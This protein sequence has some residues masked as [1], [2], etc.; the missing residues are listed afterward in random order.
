MRL[1]TFG[2]LALIDPD[3]TRRAATLRKPLTILAVAAASAPD[4]V[5][6][7]EL[8]LLL[9]PDSPPDR[10]R[11]ALSQALYALRQAIGFAPLVGSA[12]LQ[13]DS[14][15]VSDLAA[16]REA[17]AQRDVDRARELSTGRF[18]AGVR[19]AGSP[20]FD[21]WTDRLQRSID[22][23][24]SVLMLATARDA[25]MRRQRDAVSR[26]Q[27]AA[28]RLLL[29]PLVVREAAEA[30]QRAGNRAAGLQLLQRHVE[31]LSKELGVDADAETRLLMRGLRDTDAPIGELEPPSR[32]A[33]P[34]PPLSISDAV[35]SAPPVG[36]A[37]TSSGVPSRRRWAW[38]A[39]M[40]AVLLL[41]LWV[42]NAREQPPP[43]FGERGATRL[44]V[45]PFRYE[46][47]T[48]LRYLGAG[49]AE[50]IAARLAPLP[51][52]TLYPPSL[53]ANSDST[54][55]MIV[56]T[57]LAAQFL[58]EGTVQTDRARSATSVR[59]VSRLVAVPDG[60]VL[61][62]W[63]TTRAPDGMLGLQM[64]IAD[65]AVQRVSIA[66]SAIARQGLETVPTT[67]A[68]AFNLYLRALQYLRE[69]RDGLPE[70]R[71]VLRQAVARDSGFAI[72]LARLGEV[73][74]RM[75]WLGYDRDSARMSEAHRLI[76][77]SRALAPRR[78]EPHLAMAQWLLADR[79][80]YRD[81]GAELDSALAFAPANV[82][83][84]M[85]RANIRRRSGRWDDAAADYDAAARLEPG[86]YA[87]AIEQ[88]NTLL[89]M[90]R[91]AAARAALQ[92]ARLLSPDAVDPVVWLAALEVRED[93]DTIGARRLLEAARSTVNEHYLV[94][95]ATQS[96]PELVRTLPRRLFAG[97]TEVS[98][99]DA[100]GDSALLHLLRAGRGE[101]LPFDR[102]AQLDSSAGLLSA[103]IAGEPSAFSAHRTLA[104]VRLA[105]GKPAEALIS[106]RLALQMM[107]SSL[108]DYAASQSLA[109]L[110]EAETA[111]GLLDSARVHLRSLLA[112]P[113]VIS[114]G[115]LRVDPVW[116]AHRGAFR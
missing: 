72:A 107:P 25:S 53:I 36:R 91:F 40:I 113:S 1:R 68:I 61:W 105:Q 15:I 18:L 79:R 26:W 33:A 43:P 84:L 71:E 86:S 80:A 115:V 114:I 74:S 48:T 31:Q 59:I 103:R 98:L 78:A 3:G 10:G 58:L 22:E 60:R 37:G 29:D 13:L 54:A 19:I 66:L 7:D 23:Q 67:D 47:D 9:W 89:L 45:A 85:T 83:A 87:V 63:T 27:D 8:L 104:T 44:L 14:R 38:A 57:R 20:E 106:A 102:A 112:K 51:A 81:A 73:Q 28:E 12:L 35:K 70:A 77:R 116:R 41:G 93:G 16:F 97:V 95:R 17:I 55:P 6:R 5:S 11:Q 75:N 76:E 82:D 88:G 96:F 34:A 39:G 111:L 21:E 4:G 2:E 30:M 109:V 99:R 46:G 64:A 92:R 69:G 52:L 101:G 56:A 62:S 50:E 49:I 65:S 42:A 110:A 100:Y 24:L 32:T 108:D 90:R 94:A